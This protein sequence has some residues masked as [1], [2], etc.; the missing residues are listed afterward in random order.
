MSNLKLAL[1]TLFRTPLVTL[2]AI[3]SLALG[4]G[5]NAAIFSIFNQM[6]LDALPVQEP[7][8]LVNLSSPGPKQG[9]TSC[10]NAGDC[11]HVFSYPMFRDL[12][13]MQTVFTDIAAHLS[14]GA[15]LSFDGQTVAG[16]G[17]FVSGSYFPVL[18]VQPALGRLISPQ[19]DQ[20]TGESAVV[21]LSH[22]YWTRQFGGRG[23]VINQPMVVNGRTLTIVGIAPPNF[24]GTTLGTNADVF[25]PITMRGVLTPGFNGFP[26]RRSYWAY[27]FARLKPGMTI[28]Q[29]RLGMDGI[30]AGI[31][32]D[33]EA[34]LQQGYSD[35]RM[36][37]FR[38]KKLG[39]EP[40]SQ[41]QSTVRAQAGPSLRILLGVTGLVLLIACANIANLLLAR[42]NRRAGEMAVRLSIGASRWQLVRQLLTESLLLAAMGGLVGLLVA[43]WTL[44]GIAAI[45][46]ERAATSFRAELDPTVLLFAAI[47]TIATG[48]LF[49]LFP[50]LHSTRP[51]LLPTLKGQSGQPS[52]ARGAARFRTALAVFQITLSMTLLTASGLFIKSLSNISRVDLGFQTENVVTFSIAPEL[53]GYDQPRSQSLYARLEEELARQPGVTS[54]TG[55]VVAVLQGNNW[56]TDVAVQGFQSGPDINSNSR[57][58]MVGPGYFKTLGMPL[59]AGREFTHQDTMGAPKVAIVNEA[60]VRKFKLGNDVVGKMMSDQGSGDGVKLDMQIVGV[61]KDAKYSEVKG[62]VPALFFKHYKQTERVS[63]LTL[64]AKTAGDPAALTGQVRR[65]VQ[66]LDPNLPVRRLYTLPDQV[67]DNVFLDRFIGIMSSSFA[68]L[69]TLL[70]ALGLYGVLAYTVAQRTREIGLRMALGAAPGRVRLMVLRQV[71]IMTLVGGFLGLTASFWLGGVAEELLFELNGRDPLVFATAAIILTAVALAAGLIPA[72]RASQVDPMTALRYE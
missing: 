9:S 72:H 70:A 58:N 26:N 60:F 63:S 48:V 23:E 2:V 57:M 25:V 39:I 71:G 69:A 56:G 61:V 50:A 6:L 68:V 22:P 40:G 45:L 51:D 33:V 65:I 24:T 18:G 47:V 28:E 8:R 34:P 35:Q 7:E 21:V 52:G 4:I 20:K 55:A 66:S 19:D 31:L 10:G 49:G 53:N 15:N 64:Y 44:Y 3:L 29:A 17:M 37:E 32:N 1:R 42:A 59:L 41:G 62:T 13:K 46:P 38:T 30:Y 43:R 67:R 54:V 11:D 5:A 12:Q 27:L 14:F 36:Q 16:S